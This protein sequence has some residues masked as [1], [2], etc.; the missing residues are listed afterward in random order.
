MYFARGERGPLKIGTSANVPGRLETLGTRETG[1]LELLAQLPGEYSIERT[2]HRA[3]A[4]ERVRGEWFQP[5]E[6]VLATVA[7]IRGGAVESGAEVPPALAAMIREIVHGDETGA[8]RKCA[9]RP[10]WGASEGARLFRREIEFGRVST[11]DIMRLTGASQVSIVE[12]WAA[13]PT[14]PGLHAVLVIQ[15]VCGIAPELWLEPHQRTQVAA[16]AAARANP[17]AA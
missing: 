3:F 4:P 1:P 11:L 6:R 8:K 12:G 2:F 7:F 17:T 13:G 10:G 16:V 15:A 14:M 9:V 5:S